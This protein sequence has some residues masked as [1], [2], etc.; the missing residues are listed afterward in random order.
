MLQRAEASA[1]SCS[2]SR[3]KRKRASHSKK[4]NAGGAHH[5]GGGAHHSCL[6]VEEGERRLLVRQ[7]RRLAA[8]VHVPEHAG[9]V[10]AAA[11]LEGVPPWG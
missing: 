10:L 7:G 2:C 11:L 4:V 5:G 3:P 6:P 1:G 8:N 9:A